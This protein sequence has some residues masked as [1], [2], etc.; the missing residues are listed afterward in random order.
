MKTLTILICLF[1]TVTPSVIADWN[2]EE[3]EILRWRGQYYD[4]ASDGHY[5]YLACKRGVEIYDIDNPD[6]PILAGSFLTDGLANGVAINYPYLYVGDVYGFNIWDVSDLSAPAKLGGF[7]RSGTEGYQERLTYRDGFV[8]VAAY[9][10]GLQ[11]IDVSDPFRPVIVSQVDTPAYSW[12]LA[13]KENAAFMMDFFSIEI[14]DISYLFA[15]LKRTSFEAIFA[16]GIVVDES[17]AYIAYVDGLLVLDISN[18]FSPVVI[19]DIGPTGAGAAESVAI[20]D[21]YVILAHQSYVE[22]YD[23]SDPSEPLQVSFFYPPGHPRKCLAVENHL[24]TILDDNGFHVTDITHPEYPVTGQHINPGEWGSRQDVVIDNNRL[25]LCDWNRGL[26]VYDISDPESIV[27]S[28]SYQSPGNL[29]DIKIKDNLAFLSCYTEL[30][31]VDVENPSDIHYV[32]NY[33]TTG[34][35]WDV[36]I[37][38]NFAYLCDLY[39][40]QILDI[41]NPSSITRLG[42]LYLAQNG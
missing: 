18:P 8:F 22:I 27:E 29:N 39:T 10:S 42:V 36:D 7:K 1:L 41:S 6:T 31:I 37:S 26:V 3:Q 38:G 21:N 14:M 24:Y 23:V 5:L 11:I 19:S 25:Y 30:Q 40:F 34:N 17:F 9:S 12:D 15:P 35:P 13:L 4:L 28:G 16:G 32:S 33:K 2:L 20:K